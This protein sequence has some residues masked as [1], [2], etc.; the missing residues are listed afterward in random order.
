MKYIIVHFFRESLIS[1]IMSKNNLCPK[2]HEIFVCLNTAYFVM[3]KWDGTLR[4]LV[5]EKL[6]KKEHLDIIMRLI[7]K[8]HKIGIIHCDLHTSNIL[9]RIKNNKYE[10]CIIDF[11]LSLYFE[12]KKSIIPDKYIPNSR[13]LR[14]FFILNLI[15]INLVVLLMKEV[16]HYLILIII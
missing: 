1:T 7:Q 13:F 14:I 6:F 16:L 3:D 11:G 8:M 2:I 5:T 4:E 9:Y 15:Y 12:D 10:F